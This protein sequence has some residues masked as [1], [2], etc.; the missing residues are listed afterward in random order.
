M[1]ITAKQ[2]VTQPPTVK[3]TVSSTTK[4]NILNKL[5]TRKNNIILGVIA[6]VVVL[7]GVT[8]GWL[9]S[10]KAKISSGD[11]SVA[12]GAKNTA[13]EAGFA[14][15]KAD[16]AEGMLE[17]GG[18]SGEGTHHLVRDGGPSKNVYLTSTVIDLSGFKGKKVQVW[19][20][21]MSARKAGWLMDVSKIKVIE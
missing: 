2:P 3:S 11:S 4:Q 12:P 1:D 20:E 21:T 6:L 15:E 13:N 5:P 9:L 19:G 8:T 16:T 14:S 7:L 17:E 18:I 10:G